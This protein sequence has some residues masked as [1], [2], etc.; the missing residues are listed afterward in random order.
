VAVFTLALAAGAGMLEAA[1][2][3][4]YAAAITVGKVGTEIV[5]PEELLAT[6]DENH[7]L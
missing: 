1:K 5:T 3:S 7:E 2:L 4:N 6:L